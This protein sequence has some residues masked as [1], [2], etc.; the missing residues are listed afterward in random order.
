[1]SALKPR[2][3]LVNFRLTQEEL[4]SL[5][6]ACLVKGARNISDFAR[7]AVLQLAASQI[8]P[9][10]AILNQLSVLDTRLGVMEADLEHM[11]DLLKGVLKGLVQVAPKDSLRE[12]EKVQ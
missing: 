5:R 6:M 4:E 12:K 3:R 9:Q 1:M 10:G 7:T 8:E 11:K 2:N